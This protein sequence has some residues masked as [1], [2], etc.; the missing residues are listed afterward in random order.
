MHRIHGAVGLDHAHLSIR[1]E[2]P[3]ER[4]DPRCVAGVHEHVHDAAVLLREGPER[5]EA[6]EVG[7]DDD[8]AALRGEKPR[9]VLAATDL[10]LEG[11]LPVE[12][13]HDAVEDR[14]RENPEVEKAGPEIGGPAQGGGPFGNGGYAP[15]VGAR[16]GAGIASGEE[17]VGHDSV[18]EG[19][20][21]RT[22]K[23]AIAPDDD[24]QTEDGAAFG[25]T[26]PARRRP[27]VVAHCPLLLSVAA[28]SCANRSSSSIAGSARQASD[29]GPAST[30]MGCP[31]ELL[32]G[33]PPPT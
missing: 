23:E 7:T 12:P 31:K 33:P 20:A 6:S 25:D 10:E 3:E 5:V 22:A 26:R 27:E 11:A 17:E 14:D 2:F 21:R 24:A 9:E 29:T 30:R 18:H 8:A 15:Q 16:R 32:A 28:V 19:E 4:V 1:R 13:E